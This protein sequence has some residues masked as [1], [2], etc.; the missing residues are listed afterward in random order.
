MRG[1]T[2]KRRFPVEAAVSVPGRVSV[3]R[4]LSES[5]VGDGQPAKIICTCCKNIDALLRK[6]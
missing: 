5:E 2:F 1:R 4:E 6:I 3:S